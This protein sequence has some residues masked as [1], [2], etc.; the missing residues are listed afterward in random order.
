MT[1]VSILKRWAL[2]SRCRCLVVA[3]CGDVAGGHGGGVVEGHGAWA[4]SIQSL[5]GRLATPM[6]RIKRR[7]Y[8]EIGEPRRG[9]SLGPTMVFKQ[10]PTGMMRTPVGKSISHTRKKQIDCCR[11]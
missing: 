3:D 6:G 4:A 2:L 10:I 5:A 1:F 8:H 9:R 7:T 11:I